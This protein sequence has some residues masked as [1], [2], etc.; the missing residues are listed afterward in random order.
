MVETYPRRRV[1]ISSSEQG[2]LSRRKELE[3]T[4]AVLV[5]RVKSGIR[6]AHFIQF[7]PSDEI[8]AGKQ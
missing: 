3:I 6:I 4:S 8:L 1:T 5:C 7:S 2:N